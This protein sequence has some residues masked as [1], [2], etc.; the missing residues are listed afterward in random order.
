MLA[1][2]TNSY[3][4]EYL[5]FIHCGF[6]SQPEVTEA[7]MFALLT[8]TIQM[9]HIVRASLENYWTKLEQVRCRFC[10]QIT[11]DQNINTHFG[12]YIS[13][14]IIRTEFTG[15]MKDMT[16]ENTRFV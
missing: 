7:E 9:G 11:V 6:P 10:R 4:Q 16:M 13:R 15:K 3:F 14:T 8:L 5:Y 1:V 2:E 12:F